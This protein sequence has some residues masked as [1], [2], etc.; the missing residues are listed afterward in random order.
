MDDSHYDEFGNYIGPALSDS[1]VVSRRDAAGLLAFAMQHAG[2]AA[3]LPPIYA[4]ILVEFTHWSVSDRRQHMRFI[5]SSSWR[6]PQAPHH[7]PQGSSPPVL[8]CC[9]EH[10]NT[11]RQAVVTSTSWL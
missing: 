10:C 1:D 5:Q 11:D 3:E 7:L 2:R 9:I 4:L 8:L 6:L